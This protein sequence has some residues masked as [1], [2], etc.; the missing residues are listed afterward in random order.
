[1]GTGHVRL[2]TD[3]GGPTASGAT[4]RKADTVVQL[5]GAGQRHPG[6]PTRSCHRAV[7]FGNDPHDLKE[8]VPKGSDNEL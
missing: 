2:S 8:R 3:E 5:L 4:F 1:M 6:S 7:T